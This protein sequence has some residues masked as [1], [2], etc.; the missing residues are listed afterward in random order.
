MNTL[1]KLIVGM[2]LVSVLCAIPAMAQI[3]N[4]VTFDAPSP[5]YAG[6]AKM[7]AGSYRLTQPDP[8]NDLLLLETDN[9]S[10]AVF[11]EY[12]VVTSNTPHTQ[13]D[14]TFNKYGNVEFLSAIWVEGRKS[15]MQ[16]LPSKFERNTAKAAT[17]EKHSLSAKS[18]GQPQ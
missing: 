11:V 3:A 7:P 2:G 13:G 4:S 6:N 18:A 15:E 17:A 5:F 8:D 1:K 9:G 16:I 10:H 14:V 12:E